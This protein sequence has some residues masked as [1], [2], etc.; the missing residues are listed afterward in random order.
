MSIV[1]RWGADALPNG[2]DRTPALDQPAWEGAYLRLVNG[3]QAASDVRPLPALLEATTPFR[4]DGPLPIAIARFTYSVPDGTGDQTAFLACGLLHDQWGLAAP[5]YR[6]RSVP[7][8]YSEDFHVTNPGMPA[9]DAVELDVGGGLRPLTPGTPV[10]VDYPASGPVEVDVRCTYGAE[11]L[12]GRFTLTL[13]DT[14]AAPVPDETWPLSGA[15]GN[16]GSAY[17]YLADGASALRRPIVMVEGFPGGHPA[18]YLYDTLDQHGTA[19]QLRAAGRDIVIVGL[20][21]G[22][23]LVQRNADVL[24]DCIHQ[25]ISRTR[26]PLVVGGMRPS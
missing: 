12:T 6:G 18:D 19:T 23:D 17:V 25:A 7:F 3:A 16:T 4:P 13:S 1:V 11:A 8:L 9:P 26:E 20:D 21:Q 2:A 10:V 24:I 14:P 15:C 22:M 5:T